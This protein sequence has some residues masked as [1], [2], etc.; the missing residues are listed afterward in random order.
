MLHCII[1]FHSL[2]FNVSKENVDVLIIGNSS[3]LDVR[4]NLYLKLEHT[5]HLVRQI[6]S[7]RVPSLLRNVSK[8]LCK[9]QIGLAATRSEAT[10]EREKLER[11]EGSIV[12]L[13]FPDSG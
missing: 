7:V 3:N 1:K 13:F 11:I 4:I 2:A 6:W 8:S 10:E 5:G 9:F 12:P